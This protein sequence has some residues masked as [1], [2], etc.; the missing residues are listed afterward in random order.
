[1]EGKQDPTRRDFVKAAGAVTAATAASVFGAPAIQKVKAANDQ[2]PYGVDWNRLAWQ[3]SIAPHDRGVD[4]GRCVAVC[5]VYEPNLKKRRQGR[6]PTTRRHYKDYR[7][8]LARKDIEAVVIVA[9]PCIEHFPVTRDAL[10]AGQARLLREEP[11]L[12]AGRDPRAARA[13]PTRGR[14]RSSRSA[15]SGA[16][17]SSTRPPS[18]WSPRA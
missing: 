14:S 8:L 12:Q 3:L 11:G 13:C 4:N 6:R 5:D 1:M 17:A 18:R 15:C 16:T 2:V 7:G 9:R 10:L